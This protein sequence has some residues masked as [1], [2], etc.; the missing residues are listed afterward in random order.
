[1]PYYGPIERVDTGV[2]LQPVVY[3]WPS[4]CPERHA[5]VTEEDGGAFHWGH[6]YD[7]SPD[8][9]DSL[10]EAT[11]FASR[12]PTCRRSRCSS[13]SWSIGTSSWPGST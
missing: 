10:D 12:G 2:A 13:T 7:E 6:A 3:Q 8:W 9:Y 5:A 11:S 1:M 4:D